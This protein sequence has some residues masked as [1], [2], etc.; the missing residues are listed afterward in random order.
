MNGL[1]LRTYSVPISTYLQFYTNQYKI[2]NRKTNSFD[3]MEKTLGKEKHLWPLDDIE[4]LTQS[5]R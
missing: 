1:K 3:K 5:R 4:P 2:A